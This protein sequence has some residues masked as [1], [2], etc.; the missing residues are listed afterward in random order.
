MTEQTLS[1]LLV[2][3]DE[4]LASLTATY[5]RKHGVVVTIAG[6]GPQGLQEALRGGHDVVLLDLMLPGMDGFEVCRALRARS[7]V[8]VIVLTARDEEADRVLGL[9]L[10]A[11]DYMPKPFSP[12][13][14]LARMRAVLRRARPKSLSG[15]VISVGTLVIEVAS[16]RAT[17]DGR[18]LGLT[19]YELALLAALA[20]R[21][22]HVLGRERLMELAG[23]NPEEAFDRSID[24][25]I[26]RLRTKLGETSRDPR[27]IRTIRGAGYMFA[28]T[29]EEP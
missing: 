28:G 18:D 17:L 16:M 9:E 7:D 21:P 8:P 20:R 22:G 10:G 5:L 1:A 12:R 29:S 23:G 14:L 27:L 3:D 2:E 11:D 13:E 26:S 4:R 24:V 25:H 6:D 19:S 15:E